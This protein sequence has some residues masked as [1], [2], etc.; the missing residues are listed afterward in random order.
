MDEISGTTLGSYHLERLLARGGMSEIYLASRTNDEQL[1]AVKIV[2]AEDEDDC[3]R[4]QRE[5][6]TLM[7]VQHPHIIPT[8]DHGQ[9]GGVYYYVMPYIACGSLKER[10]AAGP[11][12]AE[13][14]GT[15]LG[16]VADALHFLHTRGMIHR[17]IKPGNILLDETQHVWLADF[18]LARK[19]GG[20]S[21]LTA[22]GCMLGTPYYMAPEL[23]N[24]PCNTSSDI[25]ALGIVLYEMLTG[26]V[27][28]QGKNPISICV[29][30]LREPLVLPS[31]LNPQIS[32]ALDQVLFSALAKTPRLRFATP[33]AL[34]T[35]YQTALIDPEASPI[36][37]SQM[38]ELADVSSLNTQPTAAV[39]TEQPQT[40]PTRLAAIM[41]LLL[42]FA[43]L[44]LIH[45]DPFS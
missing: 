31:S 40:L 16:Q 29:K 1:Y 41:L 26:Q 2:H 25:Y 15:I 20:V 38:P 13:E 43:S 44:G 22:A 30:H 23:M 45:T 14:A 7:M 24:T 39:Q 5:V 19:V 36:L 9:Q 4:F 11:L 42:S 18:G 33:L 6:Q 8:V 3:L 37:Q 35:A 21:T 27:P 32:P 34:T 28:F 12:S 17:D 10:L